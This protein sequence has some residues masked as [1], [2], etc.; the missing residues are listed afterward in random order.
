MYTPTIG[1]VYLVYQPQLWFSITLYYS[2]TKESCV[3]TE[4]SEKKSEVNYRYNRIFLLL[5]W[6]KKLFSFLN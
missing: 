1:L 4:L 3:K 6:V 5:I 2:K